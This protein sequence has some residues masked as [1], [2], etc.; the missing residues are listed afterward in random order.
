MMMMKMIPLES[1]EESCNV[2]TILLWSVLL[3]A[4]IQ[5]RLSQKKS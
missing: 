5:S 3:A 4:Y 1:K 2:Y